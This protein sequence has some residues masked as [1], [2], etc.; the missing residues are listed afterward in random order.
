MVT[1]AHRDEMVFQDGTVYQAEKVKMHAKK[2]LFLVTM[3]ITVLRTS[4]LIAIN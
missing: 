4:S 2:M 1:A 3:D